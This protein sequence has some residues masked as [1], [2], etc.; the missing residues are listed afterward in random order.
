MSTDSA[1]QD[2]DGARARAAVNS[3]EAARAAAVN[4]R[5]AE[6]E[7]HAQ[8]Q[9]QLADVTASLHDAMA[10]IEQLEGELD[11]LERE[12]TQRCEHHA[13]RIEEL[14]A[15]IEADN[16]RWQRLTLRAPEAC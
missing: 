1:W 14:E 12:A 16:E 9:R 6:R 11:V 3:L 8:T 13:A 5:D 4:A 10:R 7:A 2:G 15:A